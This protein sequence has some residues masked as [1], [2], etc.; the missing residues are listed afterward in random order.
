MKIQRKLVS[1]TVVDKKQ[2]EKNFQNYRIFL[3]FS[4]VKMC[5]GVA[6]KPK[7]NINDFFVSKLSEQFFGLRNV[8]GIKFNKEKNLE[9]K[10]ENVCDDNKFGGTTTTITT[11]NLAQLQEHPQNYY[12]NIK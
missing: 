2:N 12:S 1:V 4:I 10:L 6:F 5:F 3:N 9:K 7:K 11:Q 8:F